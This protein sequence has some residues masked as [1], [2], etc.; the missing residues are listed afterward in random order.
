MISVNFTDMQSKKA[1]FFFVNIVCD[2]R[3]RIV[4]PQSTHTI[5]NEVRLATV[6]VCVLYL[7]HN[8]EIGL[9][10]ATFGVL[11]LFLG[12]ILL[13]DKGLLAMG[14]VRKPSPQYIYILSCTCIP[15]ITQS[16]NSLY[17]VKSLEGPS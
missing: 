2:F 11:F 15:S 4:I 6:T 7:S 8:V 12:V 1:I 13:F 9:G 14:N 17:L 5:V 10:L 3:T 16:Y